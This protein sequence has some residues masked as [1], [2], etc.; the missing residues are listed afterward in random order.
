MS[1]GNNNLKVHRI[2]NI[3]AF[4]ATVLIAV[5]LLVQCLFG[6]FGWNTSI[7]PILRNVGEWIAILVTCISGF[8]FIKTK[9]KASWF[10][11]Y[12]IAVTTIVILLILR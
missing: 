6:W 11:V 10:V 12:A 8:F 5:A 2:V 3:F 9:R 7:A 1:G 4:V